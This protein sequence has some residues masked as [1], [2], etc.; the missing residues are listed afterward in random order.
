[1]TPDDE[2]VFGRVL[3]DFRACDNGADALATAEFELHGATFRSLLRWYPDDARVR[4]AV[5]EW[6]LSSI[7]LGASERGLCR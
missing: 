2:I 6:E 4:A 5:A 3:D 7:Q 1:M